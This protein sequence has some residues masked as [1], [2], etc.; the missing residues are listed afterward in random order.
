MRAS[1]SQVQGGPAA[2][3]EL[4]R[5]DRYP[6]YL[7]ARHRG[8]SPDDVQDLNQDFALHKQ[9]LVHRS[10]KPSHIIVSLEEGGAVTAKIVDLGFAKAVNEP[11]AQTAISTPGAFDGTPEFASPEQIAE[12]GGDIRSDLY[13]LGVTLWEGLSGQTPFQGSPA[14]VMYQHRQG[15]SLDEQLKGVSQPFGVLIDVLLEK[16]SGRRFQS[17]AELLKVMPTVRDA[18]NAGFPS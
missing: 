6:L 7:F 9:K 4:C 1:H 12:V 17:P 15:P 10:I 8:Y 3:A 18:V 14:G 16:D 13:S 5:L 11:G 2:L